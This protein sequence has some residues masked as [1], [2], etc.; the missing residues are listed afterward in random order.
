MGG[1][2]FSE[3]RL[4]R[5]SGQSNEEPRKTAYTSSD[6]MIMGCYFYLRGGKSKAIHV[7]HPNIRTF[8]SSVIV[9]RE[10]A[11]QREKKKRERER[12]N[13]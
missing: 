11:L 5:E 10:N 7:A 8:C 3:I 13:D 9:P 6:I 2:R 12:K 4:S 1:Q